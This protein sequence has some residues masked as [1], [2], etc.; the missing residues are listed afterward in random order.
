MKAREQIIWKNLG[1][2]VILLDTQNGEYFVL[3]ETAAMM[4]NML[5]KNIPTEQIIAAVTESFE[6]DEKSAG[7][8]FNDFLRSLLDSRII[9][10]R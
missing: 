7:N 4:W 3:N 6:I 5:M 9:E 1:D 8:D 10:N 2:E